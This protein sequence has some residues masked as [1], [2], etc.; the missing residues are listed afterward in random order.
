[1]VNRFR[2]FNYNNYN[3]CKLCK[4]YSPPHSS[5]SFLPYSAVLRLQLT[6]KRLESEISLAEETNI[7]EFVFSFA[8]DD[9]FAA[10]TAVYALV[11]KDSYYCC[12]V[13]LE[14]MNAMQKYCG[15]KCRNHDQYTN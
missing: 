6:A 5:S 10:V 4:Q 9:I 12:D 1:M 2:T 11:M 7:L 14:V 15:S 13:G 8:V 3:A